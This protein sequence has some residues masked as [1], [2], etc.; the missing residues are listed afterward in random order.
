MALSTKNLQNRV[1]NSQGYNLK[2]PRYNPEEVWGLGPDRGLG[3]LGWGGWGE[4]KGQ[5]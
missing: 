3:A 1:P 4:G 5:T 2:G